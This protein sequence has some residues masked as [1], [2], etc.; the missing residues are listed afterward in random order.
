MIM[1]KKGKIF[2]KVSILDILIMLAVAAAVLGVLY[3]VVL[4]E[5]IGLET[6]KVEIEY[7]LRINGVRED[8]FTNIEIGD[9]VVDGVDRSELGVIVD[10]EREPYYEYIELITGDYGIARS[11]NRYII[12]IIMRAEAEYNSHEGY[13][14]DGEYHIATG[15]FLMPATRGVSFGAAS[16]FDIVKVD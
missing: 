11:P 10:I 6:R 5:N 3:R 14:I 7:K 1:D 2:G 4:T 8:L 15:H 13:F 16:V 12:T 9:E